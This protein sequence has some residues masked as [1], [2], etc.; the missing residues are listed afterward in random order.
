MK[1][2]ICYVDGQ[3][4]PITSAGLSVT[5]LLVQRGY[6]I[7][8]FLRVAKNKPFFLEDHL[9]RFYNS[10]NTMRLIPK[11]SKEELIEIVYQLIAENQLA[12]SGIRIILGGGDAADG[13]TISHPRIMVLQQALSAPPDHL[14]LNGIK[15]VTH[16]FQRQL[17]TVKTTD[18]LMAIY[19]QPWMKEM[20]GDDILYCSDGIVRECPRS[21]F[22][23]VKNNRII[24]TKNQV[25]SGITRKNIIRVAAINHLQFEE[26]DILIE[27]IA[28]ADEAFIASS[29]KRITAVRQIDDYILPTIYTNSITNQ[30]FELLVALE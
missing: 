17:A 20:N 14:P 28:S 23:I 8:D 6:G 22:F 11:E 2:I 1:D 13:Y 4:L 26:R 16:A 27:E 15:L 12:T 5:D 9:A 24:T 19:L 10:A 25:L 21:N 29:T 3:Y 18:Y 7:F 30:L